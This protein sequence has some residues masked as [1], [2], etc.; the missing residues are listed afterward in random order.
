[1]VIV[2]RLSARKQYPAEDIEISIKKRIKV[3]LVVIN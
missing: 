2:C 1:M 3:V